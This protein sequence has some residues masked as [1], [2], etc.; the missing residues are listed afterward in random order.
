MKM[1][2]SLATGY[3]CWLEDPADDDGPEHAWQCWGRASVGEE[4]KG[5]SVALSCKVI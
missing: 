3:S 2:L 1:N 5:F 4:A